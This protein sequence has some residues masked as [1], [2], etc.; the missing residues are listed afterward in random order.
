MYEEFKTLAL[1][2]KLKHGSSAGMQSLMQ[3]YG[4]ALLGHR[5]V[6]DDRISRHYVEMVQAERNDEDRPAFKK[7]RNAWRNGAFS[8][9]NRHKIMKI[10]GDDLRHELDR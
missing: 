9:M 2:D 3:Y 6:L 1:E 4:E 7:L 5:T 10:I 8:H